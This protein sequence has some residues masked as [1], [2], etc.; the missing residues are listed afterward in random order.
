MGVYLRSFRVLVTKKVLNGANIVAGF[1]QVCRKA[2]AEGV[3][4]HGFSYSCNLACRPDSLL[5]RA[6]VNVMPAEDATTRIF[7]NKVSRKGVLPGPFRASV[8]IFAR[9]RVGEVDTAVTLG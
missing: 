7:G 1:K 4:T 3:W 9:Q 5:Q 6:F 2:V 8:G